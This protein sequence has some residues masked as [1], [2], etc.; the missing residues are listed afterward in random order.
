MCLI[1]DVL[2][3]FHAF[4]RLMKN[5]LKWMRNALKWHGKHVFEVGRSMEESATKIGSKGEK[6]ATRDL[7]VFGC[8]AK[9]RPWQWRSHGCDSKQ[10]LVTAVT[11]KI[12]AVTPLLTAQK[13]RS[14][15]ADFG[16]FLWT[17]GGTFGMTIVRVFTTCKGYK[18]PLLFTS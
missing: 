12:T 15:R 10:K 6:I 9:S 4:C 1:V 18:Y 7:A 8:Q 13:V 2:I 5:G 16:A 3:C 11:P 17:F 14:A